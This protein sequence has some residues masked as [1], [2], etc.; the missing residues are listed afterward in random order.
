MRRRSRVM[1]A[2][3]SV[4]SF[5]GGRLG[6][7]PDSFPA[8]APGN[9]LAP[10][11]TFKRAGAVTDSSGCRREVPPV[12]GRRSVSPRRSRPP[13]QS[14]REGLGVELH[15]GADVEKTVVSAYRLRT[16]TGRARRRRT[17]SLLESRPV[18]P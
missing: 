10:G 6:L 8:L 5:M 2:V 7:P 17:G 1:G 18:L 16:R 14:R 15:V 11:R 13:G 4:V 3:R 12:G 9:R